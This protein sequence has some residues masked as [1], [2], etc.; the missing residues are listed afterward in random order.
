MIYIKK[1]YLLALDYEKAFDTL[2]PKVTK[3]LLLAH[4]WDPKLV[5]FLCNIWDHQGRFLC[6]KYHIHKHPLG[7]LIISLW[8]Q[9]G[10]RFIQ[11]Q[12]PGHDAHPT[13]Y[14]DD[15]TITASSAPA[16]HAQWTAW[17]DRSR[18]V[19]LI[20]NH[21]K[22]CVSLRPKDSTL[23]SA[24]FP[25]QAQVAK[26]ARALGAVTVWSA[27]EEKSRIAASVRTIRLLSTMG[28][29]L[30][31]FLRTVGQ[32]ALSKASFGWTKT[33]CDNLWTACWVAAGKSVIA[34]PSSG[35][36]FSGRLSSRCAVGPCCGTP[37]ASKVAPLG[38]SVLGPLCCYK[39]LVTWL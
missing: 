27:S 19:G 5:N 14:L 2:D 29:P 24:V 20:E 16:L 26:C 4:N 18:R 23:L 30:A 22:V 34:L 12:L 39:L 35:P 11:S 38:R 32:F 37:V 33:V 9:S 13:L 36:P 1:G 8:V 3:E 25:D 31:V 28:L 17:D 7:P 21:N 15:R 6:W 10:V